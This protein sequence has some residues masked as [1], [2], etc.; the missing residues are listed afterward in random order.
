MFRQF[1]VNGDRTSHNASPQKPYCGEAQRERESNWEG[2]SRFCLLRPHGHCSPAAAACW[3][4][5]IPFLGHWQLLL[6]L[7]ELLLLTQSHVW[8]IQV[9]PRGDQGWPPP[10]LPDNIWRWIKREEGGRLQTENR[11]GLSFSLSCFHT[12]TPGSRKPTCN[13]CGQKFMQKSQL[14]VHDEFHKIEN[15]GKKVF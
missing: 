6:L 9:S 7:L 15:N 11:G 3:P 13:V 10:R 8:S 4:W 14:T 1:H 2:T 12:H 5:P